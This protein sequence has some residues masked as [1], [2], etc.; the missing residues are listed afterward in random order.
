MPSNVLKMEDQKIA[1][2]QWLLRRE[3]TEREAYGYRKANL[4]ARSGRP[5]L[6]GCRSWVT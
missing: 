4:L 5:S 3:P 2:K 6:P 1:K